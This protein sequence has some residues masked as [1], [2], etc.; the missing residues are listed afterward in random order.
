MSKRTDNL[1]KGLRRRTQ[2]I[3]GIITE[4]QINVGIL[5]KESDPDAYFRWYLS[6]HA[7]Q[8]LEGLTTE[9]LEKLN[10]YYEYKKL[11]W[12]HRMW[13]RGN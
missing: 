3:D 11:P 9:S 5:N 10:E 13:R 8:N 12:W 4:M 6:Y 2:A 1:I 7:I